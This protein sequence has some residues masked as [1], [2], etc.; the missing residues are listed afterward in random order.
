[1]DFGISEIAAAA[2]IASSIA[3]MGTGIASAVQNSRQANAEAKAIGKQTEMDVA[4]ERRQN[5]ELLSKQRALGAASGVDI[6]SGSPLETALKAAYEGEMNAQ[7]IQYQGD[8]RKQ[9]KKFEARQY[10]NSIYGTA[11]G[12]L[13]NSASLLGRFA[14]KS[15]LAPNQGP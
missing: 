9:S 13:L 4:A 6:T 2:S 1:M 10:Q 5:E 14:N 3:S 8:L 11:V 7:K 15:P 12:G